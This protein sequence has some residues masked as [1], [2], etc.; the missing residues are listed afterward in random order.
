MWVWVLGRQVGG[1]LGVCAPLGNPCGVPLACGLGAASEPRPST[2][3]LCS[4][5]R[6]H[7]QLLVLLQYLLLETRV[8][9]TTDGSAGNTVGGTIGGTVGVEVEL[10]TGLLHTVRAW[11]RRCLVDQNKGALAR[12]GKGGG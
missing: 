6:P 8:G 10:S 3:T 4:L 11:L 2:R 1:A 12:G 9:G 7:T 5:I